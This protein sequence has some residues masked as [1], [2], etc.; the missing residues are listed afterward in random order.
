MTMF[1]ELEKIWKEA[2]I[3][4]FKV[5]FWHLPGEREKETMKNLSQ[6]I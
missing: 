4:F 5:L 3:T 1:S 6:D 2:V